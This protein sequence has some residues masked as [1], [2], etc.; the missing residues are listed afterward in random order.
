MK[1]T[2]KILRTT[3]FLSIIITL[4]IVAAFETEL[5]EEGALADQSYQHIHIL[6]QAVM[7]VV[8]LTTIP[9]SLK[10]FHIRFVHDR[11]SDDESRMPTHLLHW[12][13]LRMAMLCLPMMADMT[14]YY[15]FGADVRFFYLS[16]ITFL[17]LFFIYP[18]LERCLQECGID[19]NEEQFIEPEEPSSNPNDTKQA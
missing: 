2:A 6:L 19:M 13:V 16:V 18:S 8:A 1:R 4:L 12:G 14:F 7:I 11:L 10:L 17:C 3:F 5:L 15:I 9:L